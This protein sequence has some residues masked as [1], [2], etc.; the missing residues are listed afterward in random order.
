MSYLILFL[1]SDGSAKNISAKGQTLS[2]TALEVLTVSPS[3]RCMRQSDT[4]PLLRLIDLAFGLFRSPAGTLRVSVAIVYGIICHFTFAAA[5]LA[6]MI[7]MFY[8]M[9]ETFGRVQAPWSIFANAMLVLQF[10]VVHSLLLSHR[11]AWALAKL[12]PRAFGTTLVTTIYAT[13]ASGQLLALFVFWTP[14]GVIWWEAEGTAFAIICCLYMVSWMLL[15][16][17]SY[18]AGAEVQ[19]GALGWMSLV[20]NIKPVFPNMPTKGLFSV[21]RQPIYVS[22]ALTTWTVPVWTPDQFCLAIA[23]TTYC[24]LAPQLKESRFSKRYGAEFETYKRNVPYAVPRI[25]RSKN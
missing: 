25:C 10:P 12:A 16:W 11:G 7:A 5:V 17:A 23:L 1:F 21:I 13:I 6:M 8:G 4:G 18:D 15:I 2:I 22:F 3:S 14:S 20:Q 9:A 19:S 24:L